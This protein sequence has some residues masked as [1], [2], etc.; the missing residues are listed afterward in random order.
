MI[1]IW[2]GATAIKSKA[3]FSV[4]RGSTRTYYQ[5]SPGNHA[6]SYAEFDAFFDSDSSAE[7]AVSPTQGVLEP[8]GN[9]S[10]TTFVVSYKPTEYGNYGA[11]IDV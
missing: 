9:S 5:S 7:F 11:N 8:A 3:Y 6:A 10:G 2:P 1:M 4:S